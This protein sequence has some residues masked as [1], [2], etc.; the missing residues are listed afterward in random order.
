MLPCWNLARL[1]RAAICSMVS[2]GVES[3]SIRDSDSL[4]SALE[5]AASWSRV[6]LPVLMSCVLTPLRS[7]ASRKTSCS[8]GIS[9]EN[10]A[11]QPRPVAACACSICSVAAVF[12][13]PGGAA[14][15][16]R[17]PLC[18]VNAC[19]TPGRPTGRPA[20]QSLLRRSFRLSHASDATSAS[21]LSPPT[22]V[23][24]LAWPTRDRLE[25]MK[26]VRVFARFLAVCGGGLSR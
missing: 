2:P 22:F 1:T 12:P 26:P 11:H 19:E 13:V 9:S 24:L 4:P 3:T 8:S 6:S 14:R 17:S 25:A 15:Q 21:G 16:R 5:T 10:I 23:S 18:N 20:D 7:A